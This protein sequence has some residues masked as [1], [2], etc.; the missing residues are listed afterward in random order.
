MVSVLST[1]FGPVTQVMR[2]A[3]RCRRF[4]SLIFSVCLLVVALLNT[5]IRLKGRLILLNR[6][7]FNSLRP[8]PKILRA[9]TASW[10]HG[11]GLGYVEIGGRHRLENVK[12]LRSS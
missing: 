2:L 7:S 3:V 12:L 4:S 10:G 1:V 6:F 9:T 5:L 8:P 11:L